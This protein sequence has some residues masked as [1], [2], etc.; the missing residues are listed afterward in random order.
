LS[1]AI[2]VVEFIQSW[3]DS[4]LKVLT[5]MEAQ[6]LATVQVFDLCVCWSVFCVFDAWSD[7]AFRVFGWSVF[8]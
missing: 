2:G 1:A 5:Y 6:A 4:V 8:V 3:T 7:F